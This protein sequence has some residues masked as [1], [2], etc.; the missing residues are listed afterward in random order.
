MLANY[1][2]FHSFATI[3]IE[4]ISKVHIERFAMNLR[5]LNSQDKDGRTSK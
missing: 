5:F 1:V 4:K 3:G 2:S